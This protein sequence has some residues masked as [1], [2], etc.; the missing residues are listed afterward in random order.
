MRANKKVVQLS[1]GTLSVLIA[2]VSRST[3]PVEKEQERVSGDSSEVLNK[4]KGREEPK[5]Q[6][7]RFVE[8]NQK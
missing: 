4:N 3:L 6:D 1:A 5:R 2:Q 8:L 7:S